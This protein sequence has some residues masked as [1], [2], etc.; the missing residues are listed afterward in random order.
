VTAKRTQSC[1]EITHCAPADAMSWKLNVIL[2]GVGMTFVTVLGLVKWTIDRVEQ[3][4]AR[5]V[6]AAEVR[7]TS[8]ADKAIN[9][10]RD[11]WR[12]ELARLKAPPVASTA[13]R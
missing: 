4:E 2:T 8:V 9:E 7:A 10:A 3:V 5:A 6:E 11:E 12:E 13:Q 1:A